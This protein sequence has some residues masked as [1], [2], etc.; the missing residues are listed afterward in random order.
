MPV[1]RLADSSDRSQ[2]C[3][4]HTSSTEK[5]LLGMGLILWRLNTQESSLAMWPIFYA[6]IPFDTVYSSSNRSTSTSW[7][8]DQGRVPKP[9]VSAQA[10]EGHARDTVPQSPAKILTTREI[11]QV[12]FLWAE[13]RVV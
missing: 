11:Q 10:A 9:P 2:A 5:T 7:S 4:R 3:V 6:I 1:L 13:I 12:C 8:M